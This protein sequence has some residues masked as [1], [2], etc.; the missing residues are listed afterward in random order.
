MYLLDTHTILWYF[1]DNEKLSD[2]MKKVI[3]ESEKVFVSIASFWEMQIKEG[4]G[5]LP[6]KDAVNKIEKLCNE[7]N[8]DVLPINLEHIKYLKKLPYI[9]NDP[10]DRVIVCQACVENLTIISKDSNIA[11]YNVNVIW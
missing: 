4:I 6:V 1:S 3:D 2:E 10:F 11:K 9:H 7:N 5:K 8:I